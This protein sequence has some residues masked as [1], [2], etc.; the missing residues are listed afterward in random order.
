MTTAEAIE[1]GG[2]PPS[3]QAPDTAGRLWRRSPRWLFHVALVPPTLGLLWS[4]SVPGFAYFLWL[5]SAALLAVGA[6]IW[7][8]RSI[9]YLVARRRGRSDGRTSWF[10]VAPVAGLLVLALILIDVPLRAR[11]AVSRSGFETVVQEAKK[12][13]SFS[14]IGNQ[15]VGLYQVLHVYSQGEAVIFYEKT[16]A[17][18]DDAGFAYLPHGPF[19]GLENGGFERPEFW[20]LGGHWYAWTASW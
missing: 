19:S 10:L 7:A 2:R 5:G 13:E 9:S 8:A 17:F 12:D 4:C 6:F 11:W 16:G 1:A 3:E 14:S 20:H 15:R 18:S